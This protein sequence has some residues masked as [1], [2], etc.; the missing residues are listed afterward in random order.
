[1]SLFKRLFKRNDNK[2]TKKSEE[3]A[4]NQSSNTPKAHEARRYHV[5]LN[6]DEKS[7]N[8]KKWRVRMEQSRKTIK[9]FNTQAEAIEYATRRAKA[10]RTS[11]VIHKLDGTIRKQDYSKQNNT[12]PRNSEE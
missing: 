1:M 4:E 6:R 10:A 11:L 12:Q 7:D 8:Y 3:P 5:S 2:R 9:H